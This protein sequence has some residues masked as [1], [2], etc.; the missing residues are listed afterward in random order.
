M[1]KFQLDL[2]SKLHCQSYAN[3]TQNSLYWRYRSERT[4]H[5]RR[6]LNHAAS[7]RIS[8]IRIYN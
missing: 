6:V 2:N 7:L 3:D 5:F 8:K 1:T 4:V